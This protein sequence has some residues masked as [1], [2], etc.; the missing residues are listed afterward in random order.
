[1]GRPKKTQLFKLT[2][3]TNR[4]GSKSWKVAGTPPEG[5]RIRK[6]FATKAEAIQS[7]ADLEIEYAGH[8]V[9]SSLQRTRLTPDELASAEAAVSALPGRD[10]SKIARHYLALESRVAAKGIDLDGAIS[11]AESH[12]RSEIQ[13]VSVLNG[14]QE[15]IESKASRAKKTR[16]HYETC[17]KLLLKP[18]PNKSIHSFTISDVEKV[19]RRYKNVNS[20]KTYQR[21]LNTFF[22]WCVRHHYTLE[23]PCSRLDKIEGEITEINVLALKEV[24]RLLFAAATYQQGVAAPVVAIGLFA[25]LRPSEIDE[26]KPSDI[27]NGLIRVSGGKMRR[28]LK[29]SVPVPAVLVKWLEAH[30]FKGVP[31]GWDSKRRTLRDATKARNWG[32]DILR[33]TSITFQAER[34]KNE[35]MTAFNNGT[36]KQMMDQHYRNLIDDE[37]AVEKFWDLTP[38]K[39]LKER[40][41]VAIPARKRVDWPSKAKLKKLVWQKPL[42]HA[43]KEIGVSDV[44]LKKHCLKL[45]VELPPRGHWLKR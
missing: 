1:M 5:K 16:D 40:T 25:G 28:K 13:V 23:N 37:I 34:D 17:L 6:N 24:K 26:L 31:D 10:I 41:E 7:M 3:F 12:Y 29:R 21:A 20:K 22:D 42:V 36:S 39:I 45:A 15:F 4:S 44:A 14:Y 38:E 27:V 8:S 18:D 32:Q 33:H 35:A 43:A 19:L 11:F 30:P 9:T 2:S